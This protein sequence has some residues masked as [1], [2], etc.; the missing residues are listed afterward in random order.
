MA[1]CLAR[2]PW[3]STRGC[4][5]LDSTCKICLP[6][7]SWI[8]CLWFKVCQMCCLSLG[9]K[10]LHTLLSIRFVLCACQD[11]LCA[12]SMLSLQ[13]RR[14]S[15]RLLDFGSR[16]MSYWHAQA[17]RQTWQVLPH[18]PKALFPLFPSDGCMAGCHCSFDLLSMDPSL[19]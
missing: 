17:R 11:L 1:L 16:I 2:V 6:C 10:C 13:S 12:F 3:I 18:P 15:L 19:C 8:F 5:W 14:F 9:E 4:F 7:P